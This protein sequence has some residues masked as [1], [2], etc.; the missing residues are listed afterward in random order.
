[1]DLFGRRVCGPRNIEMFSAGGGGGGFRGFFNGTLLT[2]LS[3]DLIRQPPAS[4]PVPSPRDSRVARGAPY[5]SSIPRCSIID[6]RCATLDSR[7]ATL[8]D[9]RFLGSRE[10]WR[11]GSADFFGITYIYCI[12]SRVFFLIRVR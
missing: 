11:L 9:T 8:I 2:Q 6:S 4:C 5:S 12:A 7:L 3:R 10:Q 1:M